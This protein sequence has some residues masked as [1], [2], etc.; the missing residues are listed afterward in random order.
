MTSR[1]L[2]IAA[3]LRTR[4][5]RVAE[6]ETRRR[7]DRALVLRAKARTARLLADDEAAERYEAEAA[8]LTGE[9]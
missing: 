8:T 1:T 5:V 4:T 6:A 7:R 3:L 9:G 2:R